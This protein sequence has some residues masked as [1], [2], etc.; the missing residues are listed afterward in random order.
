[1]EHAAITQVK[2]SGF[3]VDL[4]TSL[5]ARRGGGDSLSGA[6]LFLP[7]GPATT[8][9]ADDNAFVLVEGA[10]RSSLFVKG[11]EGIHLVHQVRLDVNAQSLQLVNT[12]NITSQS[13]FELVMRLKTSITN[14]NF[15]T[16][17]NGYQVG[18]KM[19][20]PFIHSP[21]QMIRRRRFAKLP[22]QAQY[23]PMPGAAFIE[24]DEQRLSLLGRQALGVASLEPGMVPTEPEK[25]HLLQVGLK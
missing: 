9:V 21:L 7:D 23:Y 6:Y 3:I 15:F 17:L 10:V 12:V 14:D 4:T 11:P 25:A 18:R 2:G 16:D 19:T 1:M 20:E 5:S 13:N 22:V 8:V 24:N